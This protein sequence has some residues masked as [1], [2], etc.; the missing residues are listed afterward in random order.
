LIARRLAKTL[1]KEALD[2]M[3]D[4]KAHLKIKEFQKSLKSTT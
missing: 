2:Y 4:K 1:F 3:V